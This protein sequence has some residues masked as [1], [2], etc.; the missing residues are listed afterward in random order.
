MVIVTDNQKCINR[1]MESLFEWNFCCRRISILDL[2]MIIKVRYKSVDILLF[3]LTE[4]DWLKLV[5][6][7]E[8]FFAIIVI[9]QHRRH[10][11]M[12]ILIFYNL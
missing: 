3:Q 12:S 2:H 4:E 11:M 9:L 1:L 8:S 10:L 5:M 6:R 7:L